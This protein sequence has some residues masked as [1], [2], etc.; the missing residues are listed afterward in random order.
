MIY[1]RQKILLNLLYYINEELTKTDFQKLLF[2]FTTLYEEKRSYSFVPYKF[3]C[4]SFQSAVDRRKLIEKGFL[5][6][7]DEWSLVNDRT[8]KRQ[9]L[10]TLKDR[11]KES[12]KDF[13][14]KFSHLRGKNLVKYVYKNYPY[15]AINSTI[16]EK[17]L[18]ED[19]LDAVEKS[20][21]KNNKTG[22]YTIG[23]EGKDIESYINELISNDIR[24]VCDV[25][26][27]PLSRKYGFSKNILS[28]ALSNFEIEYVHIPQLGIESVDRKE[29]N[30][31]SDYEKLFKKYG[32]RVEKKNIEEFEQIIL[33]LKK[34]KRVAL[35]CFEADHSY[36][37]R[38]IVAENVEKFLKNNKSTVN[39]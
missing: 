11:D 24:L 16:K 18:K 7:S 27:N 34:Y 32:K 3:G 25:R 17:L 8:Y 9:F 15:Y 21:P 4:Y 22:L 12:I 14:N 38:S 26:K 5:S 37:H 35:T 19:E 10:G 2:L 33:L 20:R 39:I 29:L 6:D 31:F 13:V 30:T 36:C 1:Y 23:Y 28:D